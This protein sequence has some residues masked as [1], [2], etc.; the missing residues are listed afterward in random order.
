M[1]YIFFTM[2]VKH[3]QYSEFSA[4]LELFV[5]NLFQIEIII[6]FLWFWIVLKV[7]KIARNTSV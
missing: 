5:D 2:V 3:T 6:K 7:W 1:E 4:F